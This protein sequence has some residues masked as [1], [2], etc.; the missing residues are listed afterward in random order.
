M[1]GLIAG[2]L[3]AGEAAAP[4]RV[5]PLLTDHL[6]TFASAPEG[7][8]RLRE[9]VLNLAVRG[10][11]VPQNENDEPAEALLKSGMPSEGEYALRPNWCWSYL[12]QVCRI[13]GGGTPKSG[14][15][16]YWADHGVPWLTP[17]D[18]Y[19]RNDKY[20]S[21]GRRDISELGLRESSA[22]LLPEG[23]VLF[24]SRAPIGYVA[25][26]ANPLATNQG[27]KSCVPFVRE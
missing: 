19:G 3:R 18:L 17:A 22:Q 21:R 20:I 24:S 16:E 9:L 4:Y 6:D 26:S 14:Q 10:R 5:A 23:S 2:G 1:D 25:I 11:L 8:K 7:F 12:N 15:S 27:F 13:V